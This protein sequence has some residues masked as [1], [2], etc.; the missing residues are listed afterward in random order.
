MYNLNFCETFLNTLD[1]NLIIKVK[2]KILWKIVNQCVQFSEFGFWSCMY[3]VNIDT[4]YIYTCRY[5][6]CFRQGS[7]NRPEGCRTAGFVTFAI[8]I[9]WCQAADACRSNLQTVS[10]PHP[11]K[12]AVNLQQ[13][14]EKFKSYICIYLHITMHFY[15]YIYPRKDVGF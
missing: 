3:K 8:F 9:T 10:S 1:S 7:I 6:L 2:N 4:F 14:A 13:L 11:G 12:H 15:M 5:S